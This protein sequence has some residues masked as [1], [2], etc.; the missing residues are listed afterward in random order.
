[1]DKITSN[2]LFANVVFS[3]EELRALIKWMNNFH[4]S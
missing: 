2:I 4:V 3:N 1:V